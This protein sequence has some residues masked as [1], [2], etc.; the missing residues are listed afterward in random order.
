[1]ETL[2]MDEE[3]LSIFLIRI[4]SKSSRKYAVKNPYSF[5]SYKIE[6]D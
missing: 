6:F 2:A 1:M 3:K 4:Y 5:I